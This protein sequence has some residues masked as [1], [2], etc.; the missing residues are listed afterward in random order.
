MFVASVLSILSFIVVI[1]TMLMCCCYV[2]VVMLLLKKVNHGIHV[3]LVLVFDIPACVCSYI[4]IVF[5]VVF[6]FFLR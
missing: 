2:V 3:M 1:I 6:I 4:V 5:L